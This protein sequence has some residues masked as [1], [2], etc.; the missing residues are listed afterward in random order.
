MSASSRVTRYRAAQ[1]VVSSTMLARGK[2]VGNLEADS[3]QKFGINQLCDFHGLSDPDLPRQSVGVAA[4]TATGTLR[5]VRSR[6]VRERSSLACRMPER[7]SLA[8]CCA[9][10]LGSAAVTGLPVSETVASSDN[11]ENLSGP[12]LRVRFMLTPYG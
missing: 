5:A 9:S 6:R 10:L 7:T 8:C 3:K 12:D 2:S 1:T 11:A 4:I